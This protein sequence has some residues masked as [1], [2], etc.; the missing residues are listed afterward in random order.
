MASRRPRA[1]H[2]IGA[3][4]TV[5]SSLSPTQPQHRRHDFADL[6]VVAACFL[7]L[8]LSTLFLGV[9]TFSRHLSSGRDYI[10]Y[11]S[12]GQQLVHHANPFDPVVMGRIEHDAGYDGKPGSFYMRN[13]PWGLPLAL[14]L[15]YT[16]SRIGALPWS[17]L[18]LAIVLYSVRTLWIM[19][20]KPRSEFVWLGLCFPPALQ[21]VLMGQTSIFVLLGLV[22]FLR[23]YRTQPFCAGAALW[24]CTLKPHLSLPI[25]LILLLWIALTRSYKILLGLAAALAVSCAVTWLID[26]LAFTQYAQWAHRSGISNEFIPCL[27]VALRNL[28]DPSAKWLAF[29]P[30]VLGGIWAVFYFWPRRHT[31]DWLEHGS[32]VM[33]VS[34]LVAPYCWIYDQSLALPA[35]LYALWRASSRWQVAILAALY[36]VVELQ[37]FW[38]HN[39]LASRWYLWPA[40]AW[41]VWFVWT[42]ARPKPA[43]EAP[44]LTPQT[45]SAG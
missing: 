8:T 20:G 31:W 30:S 12:T 4:A 29:V 33:L 10:V 38:S 27:S 32:L 11:W 26:P 6:T 19:F 21:C 15:G 35:V 13:P 23:L 2:R 39:G 18:M 45:V 36:I 3:V 17:L 42:L 22:L 34:I 41:V 40:V 43:D 9:M 5:A 7:T 28:I 44:A 37:G 16:G 1:L 14:P 25:G 24:F